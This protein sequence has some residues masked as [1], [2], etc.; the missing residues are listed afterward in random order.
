V[1]E[2]LV[3]LKLIVLSTATLADSNSPALVYALVGM[4]FA[5]MMGAMIY[6]IYF[7]KMSI[8]LNT[9]GKFCYYKKKLRNLTIKKM[10]A[11][12]PNEV[13]TNICGFIW[14]LKQ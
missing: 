1:V 14:L 12:L 8:W 9:R 10:Y 13:G 5:M 3:Y 11:P 4:V 7:I 2:V 6:I